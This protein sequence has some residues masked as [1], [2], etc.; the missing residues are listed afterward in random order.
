VTTSAGIILF[1]TIFP[2]NSEELIIGA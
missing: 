1:D 2:Y